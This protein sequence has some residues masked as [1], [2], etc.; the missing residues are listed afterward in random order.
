MKRGIL[1]S[2]LFIIALISFDATTSVANAKTNV[3]IYKVTRVSSG[4]TLRLR[5]WPSPKSRVK[6]SLPHNAKNIR[7]TGKSKVVNKIKW[8]EVRWKNKQ[9]WVTAKH[10]RKT[11]VL[12][13]SDKKT[14]APR[15]AQSRNKVSK[16]KSDRKITSR[17]TRSVKAKTVG[18]RSS[19]PVENKKPPQEFRGDR[20]DQTLEFSAKEIKT[21]FIPQKKKIKRKLTC[22]GKVP[23]SWNMKM[24]ITGNNM[25]IHFKGRKALKVPLRYNE[26]TSKNKSRINLGGSRGRNLVVDVNL[27]RTN[28]CHIGSLKGNNIFEIKTT[29]NNQFYS[30]CCK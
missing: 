7:E 28:S 1:F 6:I 16:S 19:K 20:Y 11:G 10:L 15:F 24:D 8:M 26:W 22:S 30:G 9:G 13:K 25:S 4:S 12:V 14:K 3:S 17:N 18:R 2:A 29:I 23:K 27:E 5:A 21:T